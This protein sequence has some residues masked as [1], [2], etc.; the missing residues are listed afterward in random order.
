[1]RLKNENIFQT[2]DQR[3]LQNHLINTS[4]HTNFRAIRMNI[5]ILTLSNNIQ[6]IKFL[7]KNTDSKNCSNSK[8][9]YSPK[10]FSPFRSPTVIEHYPTF[11]SHQE[12]LSLQFNP[13]FET[14]PSKFFS[15]S[16]A[17]EKIELNNL[18]NKIDKCNNSNMMDFRFVHEHRQR[19]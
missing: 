11:Y 10:R 18:H 3:H 9:G 13:F 1:M 4:K 6:G 17:K 12:Y 15:F 7:S 19:N 16:T 5:L 8:N 14:T 2:P